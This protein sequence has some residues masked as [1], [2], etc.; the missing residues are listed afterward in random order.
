M[1]YEACLELLYSKLPMYSRIGAAALKYDLSNTWA[2]CNSLGNPERSFKTIHIAGTNGKGSVSH[3]LASILQEAGYKTGLYTSPHLHDFRERIRVNGK[4]IP[5]QDV[6]DFTEKIL[7]NI[8]S[9]EPSFF[10]LTVGMAFDHFRK[11]QVDVAVIETG[12]GGRLDSTNI[13]RPEISVIT[14]IGYDHMSLLGNTLDKIAFEKAGIIKEKIP[15]I[16]GSSHPDTKSVFIEKA[17]ALEAPIHFAEEEW[18]SQADPLA[19]GKASITL[20]DKNNQ[21]TLRFE[22]ELGGIY[23]QENLRTAYA[24]VVELQKLKWNIP[25]EAIQAGFAKSK[26]NT[27]LMGRWEWLQQNP[28]V[29]LDVA[30][31]VDGFRVLL[32]QL[33]KT[34]FNKLYLIVGLSKDK[35]VTALI[36]LLPSSA[37]LLFTQAHIPRAL[38]GEELRQMAQEKGIQGVSFDNVNEALR[39]AQS[40][41]TSNDLI[42]VC[43]S[44]FVVGEVDR[45]AFQ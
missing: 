41:A 12:L 25:A 13:I 27:G 24:S 15:V 3:M 11:E 19:G 8:E 39:N 23:Q 29:V 17:L 6:V 1:E 4:M 16:I 33:E 35:D 34:S 28:G 9:I 40:K 32:K 14:N 44:I 45:T 43:G 26:Q 21:N 36:S 5:Q 2:L 30:H 31:N 38:S 20:V 18:D 10:E 22:S 42:V 7:P 37:N